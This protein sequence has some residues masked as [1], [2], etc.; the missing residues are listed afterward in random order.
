MRKDGQK[1]TGYWA[2]EYACWRSGGLSQRAYCQGRGYSLYR[3]NN[4]ISAGKKL[5]LISNIRDE[6]RSK[7]VAIKVK[8]AEDNPKAAYC[9]IGFGGKAGIRIETEEM[10]TQLRGLVKGLG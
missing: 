8:A 1:S 9:E 6:K 4:G 10:M 2:A 7:F 3:F 5:G